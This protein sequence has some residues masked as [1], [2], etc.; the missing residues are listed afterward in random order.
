MRVVGIRE[1]KSLLLGRLIAL[2]EVA[3][4]LGKK[5]ARRC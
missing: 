5:L 2:F 4:C 3:A 1:Q